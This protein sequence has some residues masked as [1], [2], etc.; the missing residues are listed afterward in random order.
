MRDIKGVSFSGYF[1]R[2]LFKLQSFGIEGSLLRLSKT[3]LTARQQ[4]GVLSGQTSSWLNVTA[5][6]PQ[7][8]V[9]GSLWF[10]IYVNDL[11]DEKTSSC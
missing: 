1:K 5:S 2:L 6:V 3:N 9:L 4:K 11:P 8:S 7:G 10:L